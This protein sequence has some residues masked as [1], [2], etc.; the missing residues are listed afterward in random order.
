MHRPLERGNTAYPFHN[1]YNVLFIDTSLLQI[2][3]N[4]SVSK[5]FLSLIKLDCSRIVITIRSPNLEPFYINNHTVKHQGCECFCFQVSKCSCSRRANLW[6]IIY[7][8]NYS[9]FISSLV[10]FDLYYELSSRMNRWTHK[11]IG[12]PTRNHTQSFIPYRKKYGG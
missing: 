3:L 1:V 6:V 5:D 11:K 10:F 7:S 12:F 9:K 8:K 2:V 4:S